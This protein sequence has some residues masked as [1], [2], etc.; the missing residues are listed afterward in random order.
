MTRYPSLE[1]PG[2]L[3]RSLDY[4]GTASFAM[5]GAVSASLHGMELPGAIIIGIIAAMGGGTTRDIL[6]GQTPVFWIKEAEYL[7][8][9]VGTAVATFLLWPVLRTMSLFSTTGS[10]LIDGPLFRWLDT[11]GLGAFS[12]VGSQHGIRNGFHP[13]MTIALTT[14][15]CS[16]GGIIRDVLTNV[17]VKVLQ[18]HAELYIT[19]AA[20]GSAFYLMARRHWSDPLVR[21]G[22]GF[23][24]TVMLRF[25]SWTYGLSLSSLK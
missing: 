14:I 5:G 12:V 16:G 13:L 23:L 3:L 4:L 22:V 20:A 15:T 21:L 17:P 25:C 2:G 8:I 1:T 6:L 9:C 11:I 24:S 19:T 10:G 7:G 18:G